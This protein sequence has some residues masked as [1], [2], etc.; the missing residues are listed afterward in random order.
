MHSQQI[1][2]DRVIWALAIILSVISLLAIYSS[3][4]S[5]AW[6]ERGGNTEYY[7]FKQFIIVLF[8]LIIVYGVHK[9]KFTY[10]SRSAQV[11]F[12]VSIPFL[13]AT[14]LFGPEINGARRYIYI[15]L[16]GIGLIT[17]QT[18]DLAK[19]ALMM[20]LARFLAKNQDE[21]R[22]FK[23]GFVRVI[24]PIVIT[25]GLI[26]P[27]NFS[28]AAM[29]FVASLMLLYIG[30]ANLKH[31]FSLIALGVGGFLLLLTIAA[32]QPDLLPRASVW[33][34]RVM[35]YFDGDTKESYQVTMSKMAV[36]EGG[37]LGKAPGNSTQR[38]FLPHSYSDFVYAII[39]EEY[40]I[41]GGIFVIL[42]FIILLFR[43]LK[44]ARLC[45]KKFGSYLVI[46]IS[47]LMVFQAMI[48]MGVAVNILPVTG[49]TLPFISMGG[50]SFWF[51][52]VGL[53][54]ILSVSS[55][56]E[57]FQPL[58]SEKPSYATA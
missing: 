39:I 23:K 35:Q 2:G 49:Q 31:I 12:Y 3:T 4:S 18:S 43:S 8:G 34:K 38:N 32:F 10:F 50:T 27:A 21:I 6:R 29:L 5:L 11:L 36:A 53:G 46:G 25:C 48:N 16:P 26:L 40:G 9:I 22:D 45:D 33:Q 7:L 20:Y 15:D 51:S 13:I 54:M 17:F 19:L 30:R 44:I 1:K 28:T 24:I 42:I 41:I 37:L 47:F 55:A 57:K 14:L 52:C 56:V 58:K